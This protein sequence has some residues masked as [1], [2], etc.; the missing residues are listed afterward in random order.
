[1]QKED[2]AI[3]E[4][5]Q[6]GMKTPAYEQGRFVCDIN[7]SGESEHAVHHFH[8]LYLDAIDRWVG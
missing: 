4:S 5:V 1:L 3:V 2:I 7:G 8:G 6:R